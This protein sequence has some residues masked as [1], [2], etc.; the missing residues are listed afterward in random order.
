MEIEIQRWD[1][2]GDRK[3]RHSLNFQYPL[4]SDLGTFPAVSVGV[5]DLLGSGVE[6]QSFYFAVGKALPLS[7]SQV[8]LWREIRFSAGAGTG[9]INGVFF[10]V[11]ARLRS[12]LQI[13]AELFRYRPNISLSVPL[14]PNV[15]AKATSLDG[16]LFY[17][18]TFT[19]AR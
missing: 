15:Q 2:L 6:T 10:G 9:T 7:D 17:G 4:L 8:R 5:R 16:R 18:L 1:L 12:G 14:L 3:L 13:S 11:Q 19:F